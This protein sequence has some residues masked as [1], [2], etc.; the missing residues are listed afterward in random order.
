MDGW[1]E[2]QLILVCVTATDSGILQSVEKIQKAQKSCF[3]SLSVQ[4]NL[5]SH[6][7][8]NITTCVGRGSR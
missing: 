3:G 4:G 2:M 1:L 6:K 7:S 8:L 5:H